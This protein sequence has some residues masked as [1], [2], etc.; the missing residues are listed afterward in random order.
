MVTFKEKQEVISRLINVPDKDKRKFWS[1][2]VKFL[3]ILYE[4]YP[5]KKFWTSLSFSV[6]LDSMLLLRSGYYAE[7]LASKYRLFKF[8]FP[9]DKPIKLGKKCTD[10]VEVSSKPKTIKDFL[11]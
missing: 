7:I 8:E 6:I 5:D 11:S 4:Q 1:K 9:K 10:D 3:N 2:E